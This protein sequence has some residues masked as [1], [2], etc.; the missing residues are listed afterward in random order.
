MDY[1]PR[2]VHV[3]GENPS[4]QSIQLVGR[5]LTEPSASNEMIPGQ[6]TF[7]GDG[8]ERFPFRNCKILNGNLIQNRILTLHT[9]QHVPHSIQ[10]SKFIIIKPTSVHLCA[11][12]TIMKLHNLTYR[13]KTNTD[14]RWLPERPRHV[15]KWQYIWTGLY[16]VAACEVRGVKCLRTDRTYCHIL[17]SHFPHPCLGEGLYRNLKPVLQCHYHH[18]G[19]PFCHFFAVYVVFLNKILYR[20]L[21]E[22]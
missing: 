16:C 1:T 18:C 8:R 3:T 9:N 22:P 5:T 2:I 13:F 11:F 7:Q 6:D 14:G 17:H 21:G 12:H 15:S 19:A 10:N 4:K 20:R